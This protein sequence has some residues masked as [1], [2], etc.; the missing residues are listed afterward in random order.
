MKRILPVLA[1][2]LVLLFSSVSMAFADT[3]PYISIVNP[4]A[5]STVYSSSLLVSVKVTKVETITVSVAKESTVVTT[6]AGIDGNIE[7]KT[8]KVYT[9]IAEAESF[10][11]TNTLSYYTKKF[12]NVSPGTYKITVNTIGGD[13]KAIY[14]TTRTVKVATK[15]TTESA[16]FSTGQSGTLTFLQNLLKTIFGD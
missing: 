4:S 15:E 7:T 12:E 1:L 2:V 9:N 5:D 6:A 14:T 16:V 10:T 8:S 13:K 3:D 11:S